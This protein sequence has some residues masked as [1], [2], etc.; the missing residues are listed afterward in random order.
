LNRYA[1]VVYTEKDFLILGTHTI[2]IGIYA[3][4]VIW[5]QTLTTLSPQLIEKFGNSFNEKYLRR[6]I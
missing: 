1:N 3:I 5:Q 2:G 4:I 6:M